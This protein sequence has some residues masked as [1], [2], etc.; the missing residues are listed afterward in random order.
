MITTIS[1]IGNCPFKQGHIKL[2]TISHRKKLYLLK[3]LFYFIF[4]FI[5]LTA[6]HFN[7]DKNVSWAP[8]QDIRMISEGSRDI[9]DWSNDARNSALPSQE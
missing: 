6:Q 5:F 1:L 7:I 8:N 2:I 9:E 3:F 4:Y